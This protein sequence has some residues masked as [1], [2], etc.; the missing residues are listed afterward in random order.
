MDFKKIIDKA[1]AE[2]FTA[3]EVYYSY[4]KQYLVSLFNGALDKSQAMDSNVYSLRGIYNGKMAYVTFENDEE[5]I[6]KIIKTLKSN[7]KALTTNEEFDLFKGSKEYQKVEEVDG[8]FDKVPVSDKIELLKKLEKRIREFDNRI[9]FIPM[10]R[11]SDVHE[12]TRIVNSYGL[13]IEK[14]NTYGMLLAQVVAKENDKT[15]SGFEVKLKLRY[16]EL[17]VE[18]IAKKAVERAV[19]MLNASPCSTK[20]YPVI[21]ENEAMC[22]ILGGFASMFSGESAIKGLTSLKGKEG[23]KIMDERVTICDDPFHKDFYAKQPFD[24]EGVAC[25]KKNIVENGVFKTMLHNIKTAKYF[26]TVSTG[27]GFK[28]GAGGAVI[29][30][31]VNSYIVP[32]EKTK[33]EMISGLKEG[34]LITDLS[35]LHAGLNPISGDFSAQSSGFLIENG[36]IVRPINLVVVS[37]N[38]LKMMNDIETIG[39][40]LFISYDGQ[41]SPSILFKGLQ[42]SGE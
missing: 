31:A 21:I 37:G 40:D 5:N 17:D 3:V 36:K 8:G 29:V 7:A 20:T 24:D 16:D 42:V 28:G 1:M 30:Q 22:E 9:V 2:G 13:D 23:K 10:L 14:S 38:F 15:Q 34:L 6:D 12:G 26:N 18:E 39:K 35:G 41:G 25:Y 32:G 11:Y 27:N 19:A 4:T 33:E